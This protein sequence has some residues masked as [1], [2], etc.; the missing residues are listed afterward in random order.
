MQCLGLQELPT[1]PCFVHNM[2]LETSVCT[3]PASEVTLKDNMDFN[4]G[5]SLT[6]DWTVFRCDWKLL[7]ERGEIRRRVEQKSLSMSTVQMR[8]SSRPSTVAQ[9]R[10]PQDVR[11]A[12][13]VQNSCV[14]MFSQIQAE[15]VNRLIISW[16]TRTQ[17][18]NPTPEVPG[19]TAGPRHLW[20]S[21]QL[22]LGTG[23]G[24]RSSL[25]LLLYH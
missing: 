22:G 2:T 21:W 11:P 24:R 17:T 6:L 5:T 23:Q 7:T 9:R 4:P 14:D 13:G 12:I 18:A 20:G 19:E 15:H 3:W 25:L 8:S 16:G 1:S 10:E